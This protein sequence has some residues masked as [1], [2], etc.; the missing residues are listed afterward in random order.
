MEGE[1]L[2]K[3]LSRLLNQIDIGQI[4]NVKNNSED[5]YIAVYINSEYGQIGFE[6][7]SETILLLSKLEIRLDVHVL[8]FGMVDDY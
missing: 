3:T 8:S 1:Q 4:N 5:C 6:L 2:Y 7:P